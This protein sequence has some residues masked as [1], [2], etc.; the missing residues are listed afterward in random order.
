MVLPENKQ[1]FREDGDLG[2]KMKL[3]KIW[4][5]NFLVRWQLCTQ[6]YDSLILQLSFDF[7]YS[8]HFRYVLGK[9]IDLTSGL[10]ESYLKK[11]PLENEVHKINTIFI[12]FQYC[13]YIKR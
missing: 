3:F 7:S 2:T 11:I 13:Y 1:V 8:Y 5:M 9:T 6:F 12:Y 4:R 10:H